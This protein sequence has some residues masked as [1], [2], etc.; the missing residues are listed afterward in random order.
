MS[1]LIRT[2]TLFNRWWNSLTFFSWCT[3]QAWCD[4]RFLSSLLLKWDT[5]AGQSLFRIAAVLIWKSRYR[6][7]LIWE[8]ICRWSLFNILRSF[9][10]IRWWSWHIISFM[11]ILRISSFWYI[12]MLTAAQEALSH[13]RIISVL[14]I[15]QSEIVIILLRVQSVIEVFSVYWSHHTANS[16]SPR[17][18]LI[19]EKSIFI[20]DTCCPSF[21]WSYW[22]LFHRISLIF[23]LFELRKVVT[24]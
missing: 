21:N 3:L 8:I 5:F 24:E 4:L 12:F 14:T 7:L 20:C 13:L 11:I 6:S 1:N 17:S 15:F 9:I 22:N 16:S 2:A 10:K 23:L 18:S 19:I